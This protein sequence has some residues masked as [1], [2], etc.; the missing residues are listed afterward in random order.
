M[1]RLIAG[2]I[3]GLLLG[4]AATAAATVHAGYWAHRGTTY[5]CYGDTIRVFCRET[6]WKPPY[7]VGIFPGNITV[8]FG[9]R[10]IFGCSRGETPNYNCQSFVP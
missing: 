8:A 9:G 3:A 5:R 7:T 2:L 1:R 6:N 4:T 10:V